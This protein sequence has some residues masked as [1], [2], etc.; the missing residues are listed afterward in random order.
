M[1]EV[2]LYGEMHRFIP[3]HAAW[4]GA[5]VTELV[6]GHRPRT[7]GTSKYGL[8]RTPRVVIDLITLR[9][10]ASYS[11]RPAHFFGWIGFLF[12][13]TGVL[14]AFVALLQKFLAGVWAHK[15]PLV[16]LGVFLFTVGVQ[17]ILMGLLADLLMR[18]YHESQGKPIYLIRDVPGVEADGSISR[19]EPD[20]QEPVA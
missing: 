20:S 2:R 18:T 4:A 14:S 17:M 1:Q 6:V 3:I 15:N 13:A 12:C 19:P 11:T 16:L 9:F 5:R 10:L 8:M 7:A